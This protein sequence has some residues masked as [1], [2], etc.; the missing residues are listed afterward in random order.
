MTS[1]YGLSLRDY[2]KKPKSPYH[3]A[4]VISKYKKDEFH[5]TFLNFIKASRP[6][7]L[8][9]TPGHTAAREFII[10]HINTATNKSGSV[11]VDSFVPDYDKLILKYQDDLK[12]MSSEFKKGKKFTE[13]MVKFLKSAKG[14]KG[15]NVIWEKAGKSKPEEYILL[16]ANYDTLNIDKK[17]LELA[18]NSN[19]PGADNN[20]SAVSILLSMIEVLSELELKRSVRI[21]FYDFGE[22]GQ[23]GLENYYS[24]YIKDD[25]DNNIYAYLHLKMLGYDSK[26]NDKE[27][28]YGNMLTYISK[29]DQP[30]F[31]KEKSI[32]E[33]LDDQTRFISKSVRFKTVEGEYLYEKSTLFRESG[34]PSLVYTQNVLNDFNDKRINSSMDFAETL[35]IKTLYSNYKY[36]TSAVSHWLLMLSK[37]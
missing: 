12:T 1:S 2:D 22:I 34:I 13:S 31:E 17:T 3:L 20:A 26:I 4:R 8:I 37:K 29:K 21:V 33:T 18:P 9:T 19:Q 32:F 30:N 6:S 15:H 35:N 14:I 7:R 23:A 27:K 25:K 24:K 36:V 28:R 16:G 11:F 5:K 10:N